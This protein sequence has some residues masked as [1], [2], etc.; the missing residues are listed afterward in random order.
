MRDRYHVL[1]QN[2]LVWATA[3]ADGTKLELKQNGQQVPVEFEQ[4][5][6]FLQQLLAVHLSQAHAQV[7]AM[8]TGLS[9]V[10]PVPVLQ[11]YTWNEFETLVC[12]EARVDVEMLRR[13]TEY[14]GCDPDAPHIQY[15]WEVLHDFT[16]AERCKFVEFAWGQERLPATDEEF[17]AYPRIRM[18]IKASTA[19]GDPDNKLPTVDTCF[20]NVTIP[21]YSSK[22]ITQEMFSTVV[23]M[24]AWGIDGDDVQ[25]EGDGREGD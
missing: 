15:F 18:L 2:R 10:V 21:A 25:L 8:T 12:G 17:E 3:L 11:L 23:H 14:S 1:F 19:R 24:E 9:T 5:G 16:E 4:R 20:F 6:E 7:R 13:H 22:K